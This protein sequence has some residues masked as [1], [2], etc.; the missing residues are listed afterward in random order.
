MLGI[1]QVPEKEQVI[2]ITGETRGMHRPKRALWSGVGDI[3]S[4]LRQLPALREPL[5]HGNG[6]GVTTRNDNFSPPCPESRK[7]TSAE[8]LQQ[9]SQG[10]GLSDPDVAPNQPSRD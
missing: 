6:N 7:P 1:K 4:L 8:W 2:E 10:S 5:T 3:S 9:Q